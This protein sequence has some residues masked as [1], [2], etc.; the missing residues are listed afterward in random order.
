MNNRIRW[1]AAVSAAVAVL[2]S[3]AQADTLWAGASLPNMVYELD[4][5]DGTILS[6]V[7]GPGTWTDGVAWTADGC[8]LWVADSYL[9]STIYQTDSTGAILSS[10]A[11]SLN[12]EGLE[13]LD[14]G[15]LVIGS[16]HAV[17]LYGPSGNLLSQFPANAVGIDSNG[18]DT[19]Y[20]LSTDA[21]IN[22]YTLEG[23]L[24]DSIE[25][26]LPAT[27]L[28]LAYTGAGF[29]VARPANSTIYELDLSGNLLNSYPAPAFTEALDFAR[30]APCPWDL[31]GNDNVD[32]V[33]LLVVIAN[34]GPCPGCPADFDD[35]GLVNVVDLLVLIA[36]F[37]PCPGVSCVWD[38]NGD[39]VID[40][41]DLQQVLDNF[42]P[43]A[44]CAEDVNGDGIVD[45]RDAA[46]VATHF[47]PCP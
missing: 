26:G 4:P 18:E 45:G 10:F 24:L 11:V 28:G 9:V 30:P 15:T 31:N 36:N 13:V 3:T 8:S 41:A 25:T 34:W 1:S 5:T 44:G 40:N 14:D 7:P 29:F 2:V 19:I 16:E 42:G 23:T 22:T 12:A 6:S 32:V 46:A 43:C 38:V 47:G 35:D 33:D 21:W 17:Y 20:T 27:T 39:G 37:G